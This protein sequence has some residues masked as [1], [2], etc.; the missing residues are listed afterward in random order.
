V[1]SFFSTLGFRFPKGVRLVK[2]GAEYL[3]VC[4]HPI[5][6]LQINRPLFEL[7]QRLTAGESLCGLTA[8]LPPSGRKKN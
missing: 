6:F 7:L 8:G 1:R 3:L 2:K 5:R 4:D